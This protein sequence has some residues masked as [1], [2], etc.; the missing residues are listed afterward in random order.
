MYPSAH[1]VIAGYLNARTK[2]LID[3]IRNDD[4][5]YVF[6]GYVDYTADSLICQEII[7]TGTGL[8]ILENL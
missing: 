6:G 5:F 2:D 8:T 3:Y 1:V 4:I 7:M